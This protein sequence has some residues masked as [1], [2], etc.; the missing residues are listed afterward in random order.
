MKRKYLL[1]L[2]VAL[3]LVPVGARA[4][5]CHEFH[6]SNKSLNKGN[7]IT[8]CKSE[9]MVIDMKTGKFI[10]MNDNQEEEELQMPAPRKAEEGDVTLSFNLEYDPES[11]S[12]IPSV[13]IINSETCERYGAPTYN[14]I[15]STTLPP[16]VYDIVFAFVQS[17]ATYYIVK[18]QVTV[19]KDMTITLSPDMANNQ[20]VVNHY[21]PEGEL[22]KLDLGYFK[23]KGTENQ[24]WVTTDKGN[25]SLIQGET[26]LCRKGTGPVGLQRSILSYFVQSE[27]NRIFSN[28]MKIFVSDL[29]DNYYINHIRKAANDN[30]DT[31]YV[32]AF[33]TNDAKKGVLENDPNAYVLTEEKMDVTPEGKKQLGLGFG[34]SMITFYN[35]IWNSS[36]VLWSNAHTGYNYEKEDDVITQKIYVDMPFEDPYDS[37]RKHLISSMLGDYFGV[38]E[39]S[40]RTERN[41]VGAMATPFKIENGKKVNLGIH[42]NYQAQP[43]G[44]IDFLNGKL[45]Q[46]NPFTYSDEKKLGHLGNSCPIDAL[47]VKNWYNPWSNSVSMNAKPLFVGRYG[48]TRWGDNTNTVRIIK[49]NGQEVKEGEEEPEANGSYKYEITYENTNIEVDGLA[50]KNTTTV[51]FDLKQ[52]GVEDYSKQDITPPTLQMLQFKDDDD[53]LVD[54]FATGEDGTMVFAAG[55]I[56]YSMDTEIWVENFDYKPIDITVEYSPY[57]KDSWTQ[58]E[59]EEIPELYSELG[60][61]YYYRASLKDVEGAGEKGWFDL[62]FSM[63]DAAGNTHVQTVSPAFRIDDLVDTGISQLTNDNGQS[64]IPGNE[65]VYD[66]MGR[67]LANAQSS[68]SNGQSQKGIHIVRRVDGDVRKVVV[69]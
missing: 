37:N 39:F 57:C 8:W 31:W 64:T 49:F 22:F 1:K 58:M 53:Y 67:R 59:I 52:E 46:P 50:G 47:T 11:Y 44:Y 32:T 4:Q 27:E 26:S 9:G 24:Q 10:E 45:A 56:N 61:G 55:D 63:A 25:I 43:A 15:V 54:R 41:F 2:M 14:E 34:F 33:N 5:V 38:A 16:A 6:S 12:I 42:L 23:D 30:G 13:L 19:D 18:E 29:G 51:Y 69:R 21:N 60:W 36:S 28:S 3:L 20:L 40:G 7:A 48:E 68:I 62:R 17:D 66:V 35:D 65:T